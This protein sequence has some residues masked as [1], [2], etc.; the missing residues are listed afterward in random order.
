MEDNI[1]EKELSKEIILFFE[2]NFPLGEV[3]FKS[4]D[5]L[6]NFYVNKEVEVNDQLKNLLEKL[7]PDPYNKIKIAENTLLENLLISFELNDYSGDITKIIQ[8]QY[9]ETV[10]I[11]V[12]ET[13]N[14][15][16]LEEFTAFYI[17]EKLNTYTNN[18]YNSLAK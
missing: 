15:K 14:L 16:N 8:N 6:L 4:K 9:K 11:I 10:D 2:K 13:K 12:K 3:T 7:K 1:H 18:F 17:S 5:D